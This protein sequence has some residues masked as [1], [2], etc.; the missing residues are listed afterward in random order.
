MNS[1]QNASVKH[2]EKVEN[3]SENNIPLISSESS[4][5]NSISSNANNRKSSNFFFRSVS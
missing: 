3:I 1:N 4:Q 5:Q 2:M